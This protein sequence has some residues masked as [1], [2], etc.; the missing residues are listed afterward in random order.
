[1]YN[2]CLCLGCKVKGEVQDKVEDKDIVKGFHPQPTADDNVN[3][4]TC[5]ADV[6]DNVNDNINDT[7]NVNQ[8][9]CFADVNDNVNDIDSEDEVD[10]YLLREETPKVK[11]LSPLARSSHTSRYPL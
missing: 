5:F 10:I 8:G 11:S 2:E 4:G 7:V 6:N 9:T 1:M 3:Q